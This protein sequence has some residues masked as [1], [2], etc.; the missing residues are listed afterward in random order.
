MTAAAASYSPDDDD[1]L[2]A[3]RAQLRAVTERA[4]QLE[5]AIG[6]RDVI[7]TAKGMIMA[8]EKLP[9]DEAFEVLRR[10]SQRENIPVREIAERLVATHEGRLGKG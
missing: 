4:E 7:S 8:S 1:D 9:R 6:T 2:G 5:E 10:A 3:L